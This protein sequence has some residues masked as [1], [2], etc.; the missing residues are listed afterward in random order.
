MSEVT[1]SGLNTG[2]ASG[3]GLASCLLLLALVLGRDEPDRPL[4]G[5]GWEVRGQV[6]H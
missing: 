1:G 5:I 6:L 4:G 2:H 3:S